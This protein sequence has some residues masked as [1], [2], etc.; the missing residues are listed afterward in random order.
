MKAR[1]KQIS[2]SV[3]IMLIVAVSAAFTITA[4]Q[5][6]ATDQKSADDKADYTIT[7]VNGDIK[8]DD[9]WTNYVN[10]SGTYLDVNVKDKSE[11]TTKTYKKELTIKKLPRTG[12]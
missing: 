12:E 2:L 10:L 5:S 7:K 3:I 1:S 11:W 8:P 4:C 9:V 6:S